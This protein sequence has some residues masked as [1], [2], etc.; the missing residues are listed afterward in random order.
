MNTFR[1][2]KNA[3]Y[4]TL[5]NTPLK[6]KNLSL[7]AKG[8]I[9]LIMSLP[10][11]W[12]F[13]VKGMEAILKEGRDA[14]YSTIDELIKSG[15]CNRKQLNGTGGFKAYEYSFFEIPHTDFTH[16]DYPHT[17][18]THTD[19]THTDYP[20][21]LNTNLINTS[22]KEGKK[23]KNKNKYIHVV[24]YD[25]EKNSIKIHEEKEKNS[26]KK[27]KEIEA[28]EVLEYLNQ[29]TGKKFRPVES[30][31]KFIKARLS[32]KDITVQ[33]LKQVIELKVFDWGKDIKMKEYLRPETLFNPTKFETYL[34]KAKSILQNPEQF[35]ND[36]QQ[37]IN[38]NRAKERPDSP[39]NLQAIDNLFNKAHTGG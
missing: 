26:A 4:T 19:F 14:I 28:I 16:T 36:V 35:K 33:V 8:F 29:C 1:V 11:D 17:D 2:I 18:I 30:Q 21:Q 13:S 39:N 27:E 24:E 15:Y 12:D 37:T 10:P 31:L 5:N 7:K 20:Q 32:E 34:T 6:D 38:T 9:A 3:N 22:F 25:V 23:E